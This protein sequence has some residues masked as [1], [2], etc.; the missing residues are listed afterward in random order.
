MPKWPAKNVI[1][2]SRCFWDYYLHVFQKLFALEI[3]EKNNSNV[4]W[5]DPPTRNPLTWLRE[6]KRTINGIT[7]R[8]PFS[9]RNEYERF[10]PIDCLL[11]RIQLQTTLNKTPKPDLWSIACSHPWLAEK[12]LFAKAIYWP[13][14]YFCPAREF[15]DYENYDLVMPWTSEGI[16]NIPSH[17]RGAS[18]QSSTCAGKDF[19]DFDHSKPISSRFDYRDNFKKT[20]VYIGGL[21]VGR[22]DFALFDKLASKLSDHAILIG[23]KLDGH[24]ETKVAVEKLITHK[25]VFLFEDLEYPELAEL[26]HAADAC[27]IPYMTS[28]FN[29]G[30]CPN[31]LYE[32]AALGKP[33][34]SS[35]IQTIQRY[36]SIVNVA[37]DQKSFIKFV[38]QA[39]TH[40]PSDQK[41]LQL[42]NLAQEASPPAMIKRIAR[43]LS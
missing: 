43:T 23:A 13:G 9:L 31:K 16:K 2:I 28:G 40:S 15:L 26:T 18:L 10:R 20:I 19:M 1:F 41:K 36:A 37:T 5:F 33:I 17:Y 25:N 6:R 27:I 11:F 24:D 38:R 12:K 8:R 35:A 4:T 30:C 21:S 39:T 32:Y 14:D 7:V 34:I 3:A 22:I 42:R 29:A